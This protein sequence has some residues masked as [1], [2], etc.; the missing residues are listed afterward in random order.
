MATNPGDD[1]G[2][3]DFVVVGAGTAGCVLANRLSASGR[4]SVLLLEAGGEDRNPWIGV[5]LGTGKVFNNRALNWNYQ[6]EPE[7]ALAG[8]RMFQPRGKVLGGSGAINGLI[9]TR[10]HRDDFDGWARAGCTGW[11]YEDVLP[12]FMRAEDQARGADRFHGVGGPLSVS[13]PIYR[14]ALADAFIAGAAELGHAVNPDFNGASQEGAGYFQYTIR[15]GRRS[16][17]ASAYLRPA[18][19]RR[20]LTV[21]TGALAHRVVFDG[22]RASGVVFEQQGRRRTAHARGEVV[23]CGGAFNSPQLLQLS[24]IGP[25]ALLQELGIAV[26]HDSARVGENYQDHFGLRMAW[27]CTRPITL[28][29]QVGSFWR[30]MAMGARYVFTRT[31]YMASPGILAGLFARSRP[32]L[33]APDLELV[34]SLWTMVQG[35]LNKARMI[36]PFS[37]FG[38]V[39]EDLQ[40]QGRGWVRLQSPDPRVAP[41]ILSNLFSTGRDQRTIVQA[42]RLARALF[43]SAALR[44]FAGAELQPGP[45]VRSDEDIVDYARHNGFG[46]YHPAGTCAMGPREDDVLDPRLRVRGVQGLRVA[47]A[48]VM[49]AITRANIQAAVGMIGEKAAAMVLEDH[50]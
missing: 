7:P 3:F 10:G 31:G 29:D 26:L 5:P 42:V 21:L 35:D 2:T 12:W 39:I 38:I 1:A 28:N 15:K 41:R 19:Q 18:R 36:D 23:L 32:E 50:A 33:A 17:P 49:P 13:G 14:H 45:E 11:A 44:P 48:S 40:Q 9:Y 6:G 47:D 34:L 20:N 4:H 37:A 46:L 8:R 30:R 27:R 16:S 22:R 25:G 24:G 43:A